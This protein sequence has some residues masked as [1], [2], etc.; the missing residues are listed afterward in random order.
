MRGRDFRMIR[1][2]Y[3][4]LFPLGLLFFLPGY[5]VKMLRRG[6]YRPGFGQRLGVYDRTVRARLVA[7][8][9]TWIHAVSVGEVLVALKLAAALRAREPDVPVV[10]T[11]TTTTGFTLAR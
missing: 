7:Q 6:N 11:T 4:L 2:I 1:L 3:N 8:R 10:L 5:L 9:H